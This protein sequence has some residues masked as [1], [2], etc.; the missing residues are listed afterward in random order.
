MRSLRYLL[1]PVLA[2]FV[3]TAWCASARAQVPPGLI[4]ASP[5]GKP[6]LYETEPILIDGT[7]VMR[8]AALANPPAG[9]MPLETRVFLINGAI[10]Q[11]LTVE[12][13]SEA[14]V[15]DPKSLQ[16]KVVQDNDQYVLEA[17]DARHRNP[18]PVL[19]VTSDDALQA[20]LP[21][22][23]LAARWQNALQQALVLALE[24]RQPERI[25]R[26]TTFIVYGAIALV[27]L[28]LAGFVAVRMQPAHI[29]AAITPWAIVA[30]WL[31]AIMYALTL[32]PQT[33]ST[34]RAILMIGGRIALIWILA[35]VLDRLLALA[36]RQA[37]GG[38]ASFGIHP[39]RRG[40]SL[41][42]VP[43]MSKAL[44]G[45]ERVAVYFVAVLA[46]L[47]TLDVPIASVVTIGGIAA[48]AVG[49][50]AQS[51]VRDFLNGLLVLFEDQY[52]EGDY[53][54][55]GTFNGIVELV[56]LRVVQLRDGNGNLITI[57]H[58]SVTQVVN[59]SRNWSRVN[60]RVTVAVSADLHKAIAVV[61]D[62]MEALQADADW[63][64]AIMNPVEWIGVEGLS[65]G[66][67]TVRCV[68]RTAPLR[69]FE[70]KREIN[71]RISDAFK[72]AD[73][74]IG[75]D[76]TPQIAVQPAGSPNPT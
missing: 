65:A 25:Q 69:Q 24:R 34:G 8:V 19:T 54:T 56:T 16:I 22:W 63:R 76:T 6:S 11:L 67:T 32:F 72:K 51:L 13:D 33:V 20:N 17:I 66:G 4:P 7:P 48:L 42:R 45:F 75:T 21:S 59:S 37:V 23:D 50:A 15:Y 39:E 5:S 70:L 38:W 31:G 1:I 12:P 74:T 35:L 41:L 61:R 44:I 14:T 18:F 68:M 2:A 9:V 43:T 10:A 3:C 60:Y 57:P 40:R 53:V 49:F 73:I 52:I 28:T 71:L 64:D 46:T 30:L 55:I 27:I 62:T 29:V 58:S 47:S 36:I 26:N